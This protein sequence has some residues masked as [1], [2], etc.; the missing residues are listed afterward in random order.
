M[1][2][3]DEIISDLKTIAQNNNYE[4]ATI[5][6][7]IYMIASGIYK[8]QENVINTALEVSPSTC[9]LTNS[10]IKHAQDKNY[11]VYRGKNQHILL[12][13]VTSNEDKSV[14]K[15]DICCKI[16][17]YKLLYAHDY[18]FESNTRYNGDIELILCKNVV[19]ETL[20][21]TLRKYTISNSKNITE[22]FEL[23]VDDKHVDYVNNMNISLTES[24]YI[25]QTCDTPYLILTDTD[26]GII[27]WCYDTN[28]TELVFDT[29]YKYKIK[30]PEYLE[31]TIESSIIKSIPGFDITETL[32]NVGDLGK[33]D[34]IIL[35]PNLV[36]ET[37]PSNIYIESSASSHSGNIIRSVND[38]KDIFLNYFSISNIKSCKVYLDKN[39]IR[40]VYL[41]NDKNKSI[42]DMDLDG[43]NRYLGKA[44]YI[45]QNVV[46]EK[47]WAYKPNAYDKFE[48]ESSEKITFS[49]TLHY[50][51]A[52]KTKNETYLVDKDSLFKLPFEN[53][54]NKDSNKKF[55]GW[56]DIQYSDYAITGLNKN[57]ATVVVKDNM[58]F[59]MVWKDKDY[60][61]YRTVDLYTEPNGVIGLIADKYFYQRILVF[62]NENGGY[63]CRYHPNSPIKDN[64]VFASWVNNRDSSLVNSFNGLNVLTN[65]VYVGS[66]NSLN[67]TVTL[68]MTNP[69]IE[70][71]LGIDSANDSIIINQNVVSGNLINMSVIDTPSIVV[72]RGYRL[73][74]F[75]ICTDGYD[76]EY[77]P[78]DI[79][80]SKGNITYANRFSFDLGTPIIRSLTLVAMYENEY[81]LN[82][83]IYF[84]SPLNN[85][86]LH[87]FVEEYSYNIGESF[88]PMKVLTQMSKKY[89]GISWINLLTSKDKVEIP[90]NAYFDFSYNLTFNNNV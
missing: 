82:M 2:T 58:D 70:K 66:W 64:Q 3:L 11:S 26:F 5:D 53:F 1:Q 40:I 14:K 23:L 8:N 47:A 30:S 10:A 13:Y 61:N 69:M 15:F 67:Y 62:A 35:L 37:D 31:E 6:A 86:E 21:S 77:N 75:Y 46:I 79:K 81:D 80:D 57:A 51:T 54:T 85:T 78:K 17:K 41:L 65:S 74:G 55:L 60:N 63:I 28:N 39:E 24:N 7:I 43:F 71:E 89:D 45:T 18:T 76:E 49:V 12:R 52:Y 34:G 90:S 50:N 16:G 42:S 27:C 9:S 25:N 88:E 87:T 19:E 29:N 72:E 48:Y 83:E 32:E 68:I 4:G 38:I 59:Y 22:D 56:S 33:G 44:Y 36:R 73:C 20:E 84:D